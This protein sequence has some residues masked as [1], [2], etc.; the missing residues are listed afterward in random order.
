MEEGGGL[1]LKGTAWGSGGQ[2]ESL[3][4]RNFGSGR[5]GNVPSRVRFVVAGLLWCGGTLSTLYGIDEYT[6]DDISDVIA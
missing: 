3:L 1:W 2:R 6:R 5:R 4:G